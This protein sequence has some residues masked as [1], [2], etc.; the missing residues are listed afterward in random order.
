M[1]TATSTPWNPV[2]FLMY[3]DIRM[4]DQKQSDESRLGP[5]FLASASRLAWR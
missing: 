3:D 1:H 2:R 5:G 4:T